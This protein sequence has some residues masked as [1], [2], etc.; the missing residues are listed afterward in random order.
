MN[1]SELE[2]KLNAEWYRDQDS[3]VDL[4]DSRLRDLLRTYAD[5]LQSDGDPRG[6]LIKL[7]LGGIASGEVSERR[8]E[9]LA[10]WI[11]PSLASNPAIRTACGLISADV[12]EEDS[13]LISEL[14]ASVASRHLEALDF[15]GERALF[16]AGLDQLSRSLHPWLGVISFREKQV[17]DHNA[18][19]PIDQET[20]SNLIR[21]TPVL[22][23]LEVSG[24]RL[25]KDFP[26]PALISLR[27][28]G[29]DSISSL[30]GTGEGFPRVSFLD[31]AFQRPNAVGGVSAG[32]R[33]NIVPSSHFPALETLDLSR[34]EPGYSLSPHL[35]GALSAFAFLRSLP[36][37]GQLTGLRVPSIRSDQDADDLQAALDEMPRLVELDVVRAYGQ[38]HQLRHPTARLTIPKPRPWPPRDQV[39]ADPPL[40]FT[41]QG[42]PDKVL[43]YVADCVGTMEAT[44]DTLPE[45]AMRA[46]NHVWAL[47]SRLRQ[48]PGTALDL[49]VAELGCALRSS[50]DALEGDGLR[51]LASILESTAVGGNVAMATVRSTGRSRRVLTDAGHE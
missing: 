46:W 40:E 7:D 12:G 9:L 30:S 25:M 18:V 31:L 45:N 3:Y 41:L 2:N 22:R 20:I 24:A 1:S 14:L 10:Q 5:H 50:A 51:A 21:R 26:H 37:K 48:A 29:Y 33:E 43:V 15:L 28:D 36:I 39:T 27:V 16:Q 13:G 4:R 35:G 17:E 6:E 34:N 38:R 23:L 8:A 47:V 19:T 11:G 42:T 32:C 44:F 49:P